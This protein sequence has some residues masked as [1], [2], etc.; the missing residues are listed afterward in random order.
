M[1]ENSFDD[2]GIE[3]DDSERQIVEI[4]QFLRSRSC[5]QLPQR[6]ELRLSLSTK[7]SA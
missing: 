2:G 7:L 4:S 6:L 5:L 3:L 1:S